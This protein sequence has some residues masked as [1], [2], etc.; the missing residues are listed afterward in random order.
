MI[1]APAPQ[2][3]IPPKL[4]RP[5]ARDTTAHKWLIAAKGVDLYLHQQHL[6]TSTRQRARRC[7]RC[8]GCSPNSNAKSFESASTPVSLAQKPRAR[9]S[10]A[11]AVTI[12]K[13]RK[14][15]KQ[16]VGILKI[17]KQLGASTSVLQRIVS[18]R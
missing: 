12:R 14:L 10:V 7:T 13:I 9:S 8:A 2:P 18:A 5:S 1:P 16:K 11:R 3:P 6:D 4:A 17:A 15:R